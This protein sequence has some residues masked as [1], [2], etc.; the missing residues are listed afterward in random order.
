MYGRR[1]L[2]A[3]K[4]DTKQAKKMLNDC[5]EWRRSVEGV[6]IDK[7]Y[8]EIDPFDVSHW[9]MRSLFDVPA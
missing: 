1:F 6:G 3:R 7:L 2:R 9:P 4:Y 5:Q 8:Q